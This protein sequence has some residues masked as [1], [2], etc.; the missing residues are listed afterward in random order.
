M[1]ARIGPLFL[2][3]GLIPCAVIGCT[4]GGSRQP[5]TVAR[6]VAP[7]ATK[8]SKDTRPVPPLRI[9][10][11]PPARAL[12]TAEVK[13]DPSNPPK[14]T[15]ASTPKSRV[16]LKD[17]DG[18]PLLL[19]AGPAS[20]LAPPVPAT[21]DPDNPPA[22]SD[23]LA[24]VK[25]LYQKAADQE[26]RMDSYI[27]RLRR[28]EQVMG[29]DTPEEMCLFKFRKQPYSVY[30]KWIGEQGKGREAIFVQGKYENMI[31]TLLAAGDHPFMGAGKRMALPPDNV[32]VRSKSRHTITEAG[33]GSIVAT[34]GR[35]LAAAEKDPTRINTLKYLGPVKRPECDTPM[36]G[37][38]QIVLPGEEKILIKGGRRWF[39]FDPATGLPALLITH[40]QADHEVEY[41][42][43]DRIQFPVNLDDD[44]FNPDK[45]WGKR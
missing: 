27:A 17:A 21:A 36:E 28:R 1:T 13:T 34:F 31:H 30:F 16:P 35:H 6:G 8:M 26:A 25:V 24:P 7:T 14:E 12:L 38:E 45:V 40:D 2:I 29:K 32:F 41:Y 33:I 22:A 43:Y 11:E 42:C 23:P 10:A 39:F 37:V 4:S 9:P 3:A 5:S 19:A 20:P 44:D 18:G 15:I